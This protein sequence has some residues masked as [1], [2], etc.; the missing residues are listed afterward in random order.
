MFQ[1]AWKGAA[2]F[3]AG[4]SETLE[5]VHLLFLRVLGRGNQPLQRVI[6]SVGRMIQDRTRAGLLFGM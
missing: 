6:A 1:Y 3:H 4:L 5:K 2:K